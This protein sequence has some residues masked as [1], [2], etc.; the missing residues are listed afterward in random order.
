MKHGV[1]LLIGLWPGLAAVACPPSGVDLWSWPA[2]TAHASVHIHTGDL[3]FISLPQP[4][5]L[6]WLDNRHG[7]ARQA[8]QAL[9]DDDLQAALALHQLP[10]GH[11]SDL[12]YRALSAGHWTIDLQAYRLGGAMAVA[13]QPSHLQLDIDV[14]AVEP[15][16]PPP[17]PAKKHF[18]FWH[19]AAT[20]ATP[21]DSTPCT[22][23]PI[24][25]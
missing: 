10:S 5:R 14:A 18:W 19:R 22:M 23:A 7:E 3:L 12:A 15:A 13:E 20:V 4:Q 2:Q 24:D 1:F 8:L 16:P 21:I 11:A 9:R 6:Y 25:R 17:P